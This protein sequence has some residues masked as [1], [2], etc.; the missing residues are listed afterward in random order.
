MRFA[1]ERFRALV[2]VLADAVEEV[3]DAALAKARDILR[4]AY[5]RASPHVC[6]LRRERGEAAEQLTC[7]GRTRSPRELATRQMSA[8]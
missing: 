5:Q 2:A 3:G 8:A 7:C 6:S 1:G 4:V